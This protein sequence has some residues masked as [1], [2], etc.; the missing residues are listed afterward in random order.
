MKKDCPEKGKALSFKKK[1]KIE[2]RKASV[3]GSDNEN[4]TLDLACWIRDMDDDK[5]DEVF[6]AMLNDSDFR[7]T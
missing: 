1:P 6:R 5:R 2:E 4:E 7:I 3:E